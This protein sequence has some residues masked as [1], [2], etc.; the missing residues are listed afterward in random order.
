MMLFWRRHEEEI[1]GIVYKAT[2]T[3]LEL[4]AQ[5]VYPGLLLDVKF[6]GLYVG[7]VLSQAFSVQ[8]PAEWHRWLDSE[9]SSW[10][11]EKNS[12]IMLRILPS[13]MEIIPTLI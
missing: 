4:E 6:S 10:S 13:V 12:I 3:H 9:T 8:L 11:L 1:A 2:V 7:L 5:Y